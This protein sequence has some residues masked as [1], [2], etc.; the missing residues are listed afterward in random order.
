VPSVADQPSAD[1]S[2][3]GEQPASEW[4]WYR[5]DSELRPRLIKLAMARYGFCR[6]DAED[7]VQ[8]VFQRVL[9]KRHRARCPEAYLRTAFY[10]RCADLMRDSSRRAAVP[11]TDEVAD[12]PLPRLLAAMAVNG[13]LRR[14]SPSC[15]SLITA[16]CLERQTLAETA[17]DIESTVKAAWKRINR[18]LS[19]LLQ[20]LS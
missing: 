7:L 16:Y 15:R 6:E 2:R 11:L 19:R 20:C 1:L 5:L 14:V 9:V 12:D 3:L 4:D 10:H 18:C 17:S 8:D 13:A